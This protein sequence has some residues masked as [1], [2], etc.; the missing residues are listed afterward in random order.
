MNKHRKMVVMGKSGA[1]SL[2]PSATSD[3]TGWWDSYDAATLFSDAGTTP[4]AATEAVYQMNDKSGNSRNWVQA[5]AARRPINSGTGLTFD[6]TNNGMGGLQIGHIF[7]AGAKTLMIAFKPAAAK[8][9]HA[10]FGDV[11]GYWNMSAGDDAVNGVWKVVNYGGSEV[12]AGV[13]QVTNTALLYTYVHSGGNM[14]D[15]KNKLTATTPVASGN[16]TGLTTVIYLGGLFG[17]SNMFNGTFYGAAAWNV[18]LGA[19]I[20][21]VQQWFM[22]R[23]GIA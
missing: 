17:T 20:P 9:G 11:A 2:I 19:D 15:Q 8:N 1:P 23:Y 5:T 4:A 14:Y 6:G 10:L 7:A 22:N 3:L 16:T 21:A 12:T 13:T 18:N